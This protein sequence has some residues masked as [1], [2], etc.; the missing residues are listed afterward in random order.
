M[1]KINNESRDA[2][3]DELCETTVQDPAVD[4]LEAWEIADAVLESKWLAAD[5]KAQH[6]E[7]V[8]ILLTDLQRDWVGTDDPS[9]DPVVAFL[10]DYPNPYLEASDV[11]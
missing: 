9:G 2:L 6:A 3:I 10:A 7:A 8:D 5:R 1:N 11:E 4:I